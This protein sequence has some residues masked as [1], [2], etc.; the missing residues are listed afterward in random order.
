MYGLR[1]KIEAKS[2][3][4]RINVWYH[5]LKPVKGEGTIFIESDKWPEELKKLSPKL[6]AFQPNGELQVSCWGGG[7]LG[8]FGFTLVPYPIKNIGFNKLALG[9]NS[10]IWY[11]SP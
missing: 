11:S 6:V 5:S 9:K 1:D 4:D 8:G 2:S 3:L 7:F 10:Y